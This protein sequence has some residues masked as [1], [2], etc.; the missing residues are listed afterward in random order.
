MQCGTIRHTAERPVGAPQTL[1][2]VSR[3]H[4]L[5]ALPADLPIQELM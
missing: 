2:L 5:Q 4:E 3:T 1:E